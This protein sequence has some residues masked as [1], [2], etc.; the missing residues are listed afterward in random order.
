[1]V[2]IMKDV[3]A[4]SGQYGAR[5]AGLKPK[6]KTALAA[7]GL[8]ALLK[9]K[10]RHDPRLDGPRPLTPLQVQHLNGIHDC[11]LVTQAVTYP[12]DNPAAT[13]IGRLDSYVIPY[14]EFKALI[15]DGLVTH[16]ANLTAAAYNALAELQEG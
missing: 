13:I 16:S 10:G 7:V 14:D 8:T 4:A 9:S 2:D 6:I 11:G 5:V 15:D 1:M 3:T 12:A